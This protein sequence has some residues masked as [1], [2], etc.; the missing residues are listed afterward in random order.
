VITAPADQGAERRR[1][2]EGISDMKTMARL[3][4]RSPAGRRA[5]RAA[6]R[7]AVALTAA[8]AAIIL[9]SPAFAGPHRLVR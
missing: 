7:T 2:E 6:G 3:L 5:R 4:N 9:A 1:A 8:G